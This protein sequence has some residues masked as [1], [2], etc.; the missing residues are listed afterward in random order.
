MRYN[1]LQDTPE[2]MSK[3]LLIAK[4]I[5]SLLK[6]KDLTQVRLA[7]LSNVEE[8]RISRILKGTE[9]PTINTIFALEKAF[10]ESILTVA[11]SN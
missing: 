9:N 7:E 10:G 11:G 8:S 1:K 3:K 5:R 2:A 4:R 6:E